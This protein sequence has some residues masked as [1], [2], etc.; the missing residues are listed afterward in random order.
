[1]PAPERPEVR[2]IPVFDD[3]SNPEVRPSD[4]P[5]PIAKALMSPNSEVRERALARLTRFV[6]RECGATRAAA[7]KAAKQL[8][9]RYLDLAERRAHD[10]LNRARSRIFKE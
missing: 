1:M 6:E 4:V 8:A 10:P 9:N 3:T 5:A 2:I 7:S